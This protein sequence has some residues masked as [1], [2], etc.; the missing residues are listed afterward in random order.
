[1]VYRSIQKFTFYLTCTKCMLS[2]D[3]KPLAPYFTTGNSSPVLDRWALEL[4]RFD[5]KFQHIQGKKNVVANLISRLRTLGLYQDNGNNDV[6]LT[7]EAV[8]KNVIAEVHSMDAVPKTPAYNMEKLNLDVLR[9]E[10]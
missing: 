7:L 5:I 2:C 8:V 3:H 10:Q 1:M 9:K 4:Q 6:Q